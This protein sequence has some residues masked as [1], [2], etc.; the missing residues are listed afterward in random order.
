MVELGTTAPVGFEEFDPPRWLELMARLG[1]TVVQAYRNPSA[2]VTPEVIRQAI[3]GA[4]LTCDSLHGLFGDRYDPS[5][6]DE[7]ARLFTVEAMCREGDLCGRLGGSVVVVHCSPS[8]QDAAVSLEHR[9]RRV[10]QLRRSIEELGRWGEQ[11]GIR[12]AFENL[13]GYHPLGSDVGELAQL[14]ED[15]AAP[16]TG[17]CFDCATPTWWATPAR[18]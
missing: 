3:G 18:H 4:G 10:D 11:A 16:N 2:E 6:P 12:F 8:C 5:S 15:V 9:Q 13:P 7:E 1:C 17:L 14:L